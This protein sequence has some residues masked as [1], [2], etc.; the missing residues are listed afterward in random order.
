MYALIDHLLWFCF[1]L[2]AGAAGMTA[3]IVISEATLWLL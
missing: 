3:G 2:A 1:Y